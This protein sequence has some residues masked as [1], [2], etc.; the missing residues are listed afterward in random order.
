MKLG[1]LKAML[2]QAGIRPRKSAGQNF[3]IDEALAEAI[4]RDA[5][6]DPDDVVLEVGPG[7]GQLTQ[8][9]TP[10]AHHVVSVDIDARLLALARSRLADRTNLTLLEADALASKSTLNPVVLD[11]VRAQLGDRSLRVVAN[12]PYN[13][14]TPLVV[15]LLA[16][17]LPLTGMTVMVQL[18]AAQRFSAEPGDEAYGSVSVLCAALCDEV[19][20][21]R[22]VPREVFHPRPKVT[23]AIAR[24]VP[25]ADRQRGYPRLAKVVRALFNYRRKTLGK[26]VKSA[27]RADPSL[28][29]LIEALAGA[30]LDPKTRLDH[31]GLEGFRVLSAQRR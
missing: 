9:L 1:A 4:A 8:Y 17:D 20:L 15:G 21:V 13:V 23:S 16:E 22:R 24:F 6:I 2:A 26:A 10:L 29:W 3:L 7:F 28:D 30:E 18:E 5:E 11:A 14:A 25:R 12:L 31:L 27:A 19:K